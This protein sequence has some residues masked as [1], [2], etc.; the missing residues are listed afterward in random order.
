MSGGC[1]GPHTWR[2]RQAGRASQATNADA[3]THALTGV[4]SDLHPPMAGEWTSRRIREWE[5]GERTGT[6]IE[7]EAD[8]IGHNLTHGTTQFTRVPT[9]ATSMSDPELDTAVE[10]ADIAAIRAK[11]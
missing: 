9:G 11:L 2:V 6:S 3:L 7:V 10:E 5:T 1:T 4:R 8:A